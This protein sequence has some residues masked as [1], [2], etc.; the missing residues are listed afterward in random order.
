MIDAKPSILVVDDESDSLLF[1]FDLLS[2]EGFDVV[3]SSSSL[4]ALSI[5]R[6]RLPA[7]VVLDVRMPEMD[8]LELLERI[9][10]IAPKTRVILLSAFADDRMRKEAMQ[11]GGEDLLQKPLRSADLLRALEKMLK[12]TAT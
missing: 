6:R 2:S 7:A 10:I 11:K 9:K 1:L 5:L 12:E 3:G 8:G 4:D